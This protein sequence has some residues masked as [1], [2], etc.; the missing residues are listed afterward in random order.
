MNSTSSFSKN[1]L[2]LLNSYLATKPDSKRFILVDENTFKHCLPI[3]IDNVEQLYGAE[4]LEV[5]QGEKSKQL[6][7][8]ENLCGAMIESSADKDSILVSLGG[9]VISDLGGFVASV[10]KRG[11]SHIAIPTTLLAMIDASIGAKTGI[12]IGEVKN[13]VG[14]FN[15]NSQTFFHLEF[16]NTLSKRQ[17]LNGAAEMFKIALVSDEKLWDTM[18]QGKP[19]NNK[20]QGFD[21]KLIEKCIKLKEDIVMQDP[22]EQGKRKI[23]NFGHSLAHAFESIALQKDSD[24]LHGEAVVSGIYYAIKLSEKKLSFPQS[25][26]TEICEYLKKNYHIIDIQKD[27]DLVINYLY[28][29]KKNINNEFRFILLEDIAKPIINYTISKEDLLSLRL[30]DNH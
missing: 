20:K 27:I 21:S 2:L 6:T 28:A 25:K 11:I 23:L 12:N 10:F 29:D 13:Q 15:T 18:K 5:E 8:V 24:L 16:L 7:I 26:A 3:L 9:G 1:N 30:T 22:L 14:T 19:W 4:I 17:V